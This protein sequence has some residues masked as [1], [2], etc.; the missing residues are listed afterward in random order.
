MAKKSKPF[1]DEWVSIAEVLKQ[2]KS[3]VWT[4][5]E[6]IKSVVKI[7]EGEYHQFAFDADDLEQPFPVYMPPS[8]ELGDAIRKENT[9]RF[10]AYLEA[11]GIIS[12][13]H[14][15]VFKR[16]KNQE[17][18][19]LRFLGVY[20]NTEAALMDSLRN[21]EKF[22]KDYV[23]SFKV[24]DWA[25]FRKV[26][27]NVNAKK[28]SLVLEGI[29]D[30]IT[31]D[32]VTLDIVLSELK[33]YAIKNPD[34]NWTKGDIF[35]DS[36]ESGLET[37]EAKQKLQVMKFLKLRDL[38]NDYEIVERP[39][40]ITLKDKTKNEVE[41]ISFPTYVAR[42]DFKVS[43]YF[44]IIKSL[45]LPKTEKI[46][47]IAGLFFNMI[48]VVE[49]YFQEPLKHDAKLNNYYSQLD[50]KIKELLDDPT[51]PPPLETEYDKPFPDLFSAPEILDKTNTTIQSHLNSMYAYYGKLQDFIAGYSV[52]KVDTG[53]EGLDKYLNDLNSPN[54]LLIADES[55]TAEAQ[56]TDD[57]TSV[58]VSEDDGIFLN[59]DTKKP[60]Y[61]ISGKR[62]K[63]VWLL[64]DGR[65]MTGNQLSEILGQTLQ[66]VS[67]G[68]DEINNQFK[69]NL[70]VSND[71]VIR[72]KTGG[73]KLN[74]EHFTIQ[75]IE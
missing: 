29:G 24:E 41:E 54:Q 18:A 67:K 59:P 5:S 47:E 66:V 43:A 15:P 64:K 52:D 45:W 73:Y 26:A 56:N 32:P 70:G 33:E 65:K 8:Q 20:L 25:R 46:Q 53:I 63:L 21:P 14:I 34:S 17:L 50:K 19:E 13:L 55:N 11:E 74:Q 68:V 42:F 38:F 22:K 12:N 71:L 58:Y 72:L 16:N 51:L 36:V 27:E 6:E 75:F 37:D 2:D 31:V 28:H 4:I 60:S 35:L 61:P 9:W 69:S 48:Q 23:T 1:N 3:F 7:V 57:K 30:K 10:L 39:D 44:E 62:A 40:T 49:A